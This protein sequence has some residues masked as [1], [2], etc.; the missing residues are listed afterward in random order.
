[1]KRNVFSLILIFLIQGLS[2]AATTVTPYGYVHVDV[3]YIDTQQMDRD[4]GV[5]IAFLNGNSGSNFG[6]HA[7]QTRFGLKTEKQED[8]W[9]LTGIIELDF[10]GDESQKASSEITNMPR[11][12]KACI[13]VQRGTHLLTVGQT[14]DVISP[15]YQSTF[16]FFGGLYG[17][18]IGFWRPQLRYENTGLAPIKLEISV[19]RPFSKRENIGKP[20]L[21]SRIS[22]N[23]PIFNIGLSGLYGEE[24]S[25]AWPAPGT[26]KIN[27]VKAIAIDLQVKTPSFVISGELH[28]GQNIA[29]YFGI[30]DIGQKETGA[31]A[32]IK[33][34][35]NKLNFILGYGSVILN[36]D[37]NVSAGT[38]T[39]NSRLYTNVRHNLTKSF[40]V[41]LEYANLSTVYKGTPKNNTY[42]ANR[43]DMMF[44]YDF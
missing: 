13:S 25:T 17:G 35:W 22:F 40:S 18:N 37:A 20:D 36:E 5:R 39:R 3:T 11:M 28:S 41:G 42:Y 43:W 12:R 44:H 34:V 9:G 8:G 21:Q 29:D 32:D 1:M 19:N 26:G 10:F 23:L 30:S 38:K 14:M 16:D 24:N 2:I 4:T 27:V 33:F 15:L 6:I 7:R 31:W